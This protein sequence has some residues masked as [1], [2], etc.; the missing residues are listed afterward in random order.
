MWVW[1]TNTQLT[2]TPL[3]WGKN[4]PGPCLVPGVSSVLTQSS[5]QC[6][7]GRWPLT[8]PQSDLCR[9]IN[10]ANVSRAEISVKCYNHIVTSTPHTSHL[11]PPWVMMRTTGSDQQWGETSPPSPWASQWCWSFSASSSTPTKREE[12]VRRSWVS[13][14][15]S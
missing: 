4:P 12:T 7:A 6:W 3:I 11:T 9:P 1:P 5:Q 2:L 13:E 15:N 14:W 10:V 8:G